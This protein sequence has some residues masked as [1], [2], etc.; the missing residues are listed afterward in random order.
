[1]IELM[2][3]TIRSPFA[4]WDILRKRG[5][6]T[7]EGWM[8]IT[9]TAALAAILSWISTLILPANP[10]NAALLAQLSRSPIS[11]AG[12]QVALA[13][14]GAFLLSEVGKVFGGKGNFGESLFAVGWLEA[15]MVALQFAQLILVAV[16]PTIAAV[17][18]ILILLLACYLTVAL[19]MAVHGFRNP[20]L[21]VFGILG[22]FMA[23]A[24]ILSI[25]LGAIGHFPGGAA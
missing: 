24:F 25:F 23:S 15:I 9:A 8:L 12:L 13:T 19:T 20:L 1:M 10:E 22:T 3:L 5:I 14:F 17:A 11:M 21:V 7:Q 2:I 6:T 16:V 18:G 4:A